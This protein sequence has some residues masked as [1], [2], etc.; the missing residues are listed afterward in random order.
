MMACGVSPVAMFFLCLS[1]H[2]AKIEFDTE[3]IQ[4]LDSAELG[5]IF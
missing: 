3:P 1:G 4:Y 2:V 5:K